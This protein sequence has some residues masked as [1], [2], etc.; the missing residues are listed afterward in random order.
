MLTLR[1][2]A[3]DEN[4][5]P[6]ANAAI[7]VAPDER[8]GS[9][10]LV[11]IVAR[12][13]SANDG[14]FQ[15]RNV[16]PGAYVIQMWTSPSPGAVRFGYLPVYVDDSVPSDLIVRVRP[17]ATLVGRLVFEGNSPRPPGRAVRITTTATEF[18]SS[19][20]GIPGVTGNQ[21]NDDWT[22]V[23]PNQFG[24]RI[25]RATASDPW[26]LDRV[27][28]DGRDA[29]DTPIDFSVGQI[30]NVE[31][32]F[33]DRAPSLSGRISGG[34]GKP[35]Q[36]AL[37]LLFS[38]DASKWTDRSRFMS[39]ARSTADGRFEMRRLTPG[40]YYVAAVP[41]TTDPDLIS[42]ETLMSLRSRATTVTLLHGETRAID[43][44]LINR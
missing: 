15:I 39:V 11:S 7:V 24:T 35:V 20:G 40:P 41:F 29:T 21:V 13:T 17:G 32:V 9:S 31:I 34:D 19:P 43:L 3:I 5:R 27:T 37:V 42:F 10:L 38:T 1:G 12:S 4:D 33:T 2:R 36:D 14:S 44:K 23:A 26:T 16:P 8:A 25:I 18:G 28:V 30:S 6:V 22:F